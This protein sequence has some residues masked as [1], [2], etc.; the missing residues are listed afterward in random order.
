[1]G[2]QNRETYKNNFY[3]LYS[4]KIKIINVLILFNIFAKHT[5]F[6]TFK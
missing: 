2:R 4:K 1:M 6:F 3:T 5:D